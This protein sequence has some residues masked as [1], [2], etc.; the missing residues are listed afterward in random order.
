MNHITLFL[1]FVVLQ[2]IIYMKKYLTPFLL[3]LVLLDTMKLRFL[4]PILGRKLNEVCIHYQS[5]STKIWKSILTS[6]LFANFKQ[7]DRSF[8]SQMSKSTR[9]Q[10]K[11]DKTK[12]LE[13]L[14]MLRTLDTETLRLYS[15]KVKVTIFSYEPHDLK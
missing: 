7:Y 14:H 13:K 9:K 5:I 10:F 4:L 12:I 8:H 11:Q 2:K 6:N 1:D 15:A 3:L